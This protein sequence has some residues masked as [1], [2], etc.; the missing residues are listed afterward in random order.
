VLFQQPET[1]QLVKDLLQQQRRRQQQQQTNKATTNKDLLS[2]QPGLKDSK[3]TLKTRIAKRAY[4]ENFRS[5]RCL[6]LVHMS[7]VYHI[8]QHD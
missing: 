8:K 3:K 2:Q 5:L 4:I 7:D 6:M 1:I